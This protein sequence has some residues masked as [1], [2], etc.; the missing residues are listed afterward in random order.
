MANIHKVTMNDIAKKAGVTQATVSHVINGTAKISDEVTNRVLRVADELNYVHKKPVR[1]SKIPRPK[2]IGLLIPDVENGFYAEISKGVEAVMRRRGFMTFQC[3]TFYKPNYEISYLKTLLQYGVSGVVIGYTLATRECYE[4]LIENKLP[5][6]ILD[7]RPEGMEDFFPS[8]EINNVLG[9]KLAAEHIEK[10]GRKHICIASEPVISLA[11]KQRIK[12]FCNALERGGCSIDRTH[13]YIEDNQYGKLD[14]GYNI[15]AKIII[16]RDVDAIFATTDNVAFGIVKRLKEHRIKIPD[17]IMVI[18]YDN[19][20]FAQLI[21][22][23]LTTVSQPVDRMAEKGADMLY[24]YITGQK[25]DIE[26]IVMDP[27]L[28]IRDSTMLI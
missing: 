22:P 21:E 27:S 18:G 20:S 6:I 11:L 13:I 26:H 8:V 25:S 7:D 12:G 5:T 15:G 19:V 17:D 1:S 9:G 10:L 23:S 3:N 28:I 16:E 24:N 2:T 4:I 14:M